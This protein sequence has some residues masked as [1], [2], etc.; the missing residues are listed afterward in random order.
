MSDVIEIIQA[1]SSATVSVPASA[2]PQGPPGTTDFT[3]LVNVPSTFPPTAHTHTAAA[4]T[5]FNS[6]AASAAPVQSVAGR[7][8]AVSLAVTDVANAVA[9]TDPRLSDSRNPLAHS[10][11]L[12]DITDAGTAAA[13]ATTDFATSAQGLLADSAVQPGDLTTIA[14]SGSYSDLSNIPSTFAPSAHT[15]VAADVT[16]FTSA[17]STAAPVQSVAGR[18]G[19]VT[20]SVSDVA[21]AVA[22]TDARLSDA[23]TPLSHTHTAAAITDFNTAASAAAP[24]QSVAGKV[25]AVALVKADVGLGNVDNTSDLNKPVSTA[26]QSALDGKQAAG[27]YA[28]LV[29]GLVPSTQLPS[30]VD[31]VVEA[32]NLAA[33][34]VSGETG[35]IYVTLDTNKI[36]RWSGSA[37]VEISA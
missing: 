14:T 37:Y 3:Q 4:I 21:N 36:Y 9:D 26:T 16:D 28:T 33:L 25:G 31:D 30:Y 6:A 27:N 22:D 5:D 20:L 8:G 13:A 34:P 17:A 11:T 18:T 15:H 1:G 10:H 12:S 23:R 32:A 24:V 2:G 7:T 19:A 29:N 35:K